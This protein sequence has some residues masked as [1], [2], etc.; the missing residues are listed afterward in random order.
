EE[1][2][3]AALKPACAWA[4]NLA[5]QKAMSREFGANFRQYFRGLNL[6][7]SRLPPIDRFHLCEWPEPDRILISVGPNI[8]I[9]DE[10]VFF[11]LAPRL[12]RTYPEARLEVVSFHPTVWD[13]CDT[14]D[15]RI[16]EADNQIAPYVRAKFMLEDDLT[17]VF[18]VE[19]ASAPIYRH[20]ES[21][22]G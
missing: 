20:L 1:R 10:M 6:P 18:F 19:F 13:L 21:V 3:I 4:A 15:L 2:G 9:G 5:A 22:P 16:Y 8:G 17:M 12:R 11:E 7:W 14:V